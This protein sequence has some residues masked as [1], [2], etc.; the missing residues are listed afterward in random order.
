MRL[1]HAGTNLLRGRPHR[2]GKSE[3]CR[4]SPRA[5][6][7]QYLPVR[8]LSQHRGGDPAGDGAVM[9]NFAYARTTDIPDP[10]RRVPADPEAESSAGGTKLAGRR[11][12]RAPLPHRLTA[13]PAW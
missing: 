2:G 10:V 9:I 7:R 5:H 4:R 11:K 1:L 6:E 8:G 12:W 3:D 13:L